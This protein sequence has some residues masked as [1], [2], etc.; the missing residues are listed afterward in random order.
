MRP[1]CPSSF[2]K[3]DITMTGLSLSTQPALK[4]TPLEHLVRAFSGPAEQ[5]GRISTGKSPHLLISA[6]IIYAH[7]S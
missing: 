3:R 6:P 1:N 5:H 2:G 7:V 4:L